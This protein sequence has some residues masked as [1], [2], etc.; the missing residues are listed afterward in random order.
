M[1]VILLL[2]RPPDGVVDD[3][4]LTNG[5]RANKK[6]IVRPWPAELIIAKNRGGEI[7]AA[8]TGLEPERNAI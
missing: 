1:H 5:G 8:A 4:G 6:Y 7:G 3:E 2:H